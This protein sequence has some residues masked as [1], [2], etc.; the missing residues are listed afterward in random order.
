MHADNDGALYW[1][2]KYNYYAI[3]VLLVERGADYSDLEEFKGM[4]R[5]E[6]MRHLMA[7]A[8]AEELST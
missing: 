4:E 6:V 1:A 7:K 3:M 2:T 8:I 5:N